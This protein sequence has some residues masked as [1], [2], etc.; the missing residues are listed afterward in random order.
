[1]HERAQKGVGVH[2]VRAHTRV[3][4]RPVIVLGGL[5]IALAGAVVLALGHGA[6]GVPVG[7]VIDV[8]ANHLGIDA[9][10][11]DAQQDAVLW[12]IRLPRVVLGLLVGAALASGGAALQGLFRNPLADPGIVGVQSG[13]AVSAVAAIVF[14][15]T[16][17]GFLVL[18]FVAF[19]G[20]LA[21]TLIA[22]ALARFGGRTEVV[23]IVLT[24]LAVNAI[25]GAGIGFLFFL[26]DDEELRGAVFWTLGSL[27]TATWGKI[28]IA[29]PFV[30]VSVAGLVWL[31]QRLDVLVLGDDA[32]RH[33]GLH[34]ER[35]RR[36]LIALTALA[37][38]AAVA[39]SGM[40]GFVGLVVPHVVRLV[41]GPGHRLLVPASALAGA[42]LLVLATWPHAPSPSRRSCRSA[43]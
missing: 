27:G 3:A 33:L 35:S 40:I 36:L 16:S 43:C 5:S 18:P 29:A 30:L 11:V 4:A 34:P 21:T 24:G 26:A 10:A 42:T 20:G 19:A 6:Y 8:V 7:T 13:A 28:T 17:V 39:V 1:M 2:L 32:A 12:T 37:T 9:G 23:T 38:G 41:V 31:A 15:F 14:G 22:Y 25:A